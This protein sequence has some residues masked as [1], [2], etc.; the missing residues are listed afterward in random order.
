MVVKKTRRI[1][2][3]DGSDIQGTPSQNIERNPNG[4]IL[5][6]TLLGLKPSS[7]SLVRSLLASY[8]D[9]SPKTHADGGCHLPNYW[10]AAQILSPDV[11]GSDSITMPGEP[12]P[13][14]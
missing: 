6:D 4:D 7:F 12:T 14:V 8:T 1:G 13:L 10:A 11:D 2:G 9:M 3:M 5:C